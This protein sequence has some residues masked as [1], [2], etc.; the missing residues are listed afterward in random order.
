[1]AAK[2]HRLDSLKALLQQSE[3]PLDEV[4]K[5][6][7]EMVETLKK[8]EGADLEKKE[9]CESQREEDTASARKLSL[10]I[11][12]L[13]DVMTRNEAKIK[14][15]KAIIEEKEAEIKK[16][17][18]ELA[19]A[20]ANREKEK[21]AY[22]AAK[23]DDE[24]AAELIKKA[25]ETLKGF[26]EENGLTLVQRADQ[27]PTVEAGKAPP[28][29]PPTWEE[30]YGGAK[31]ESTGIQAILQMILEDVEADIK[32]A[33]AAEKE[34]IEE[35]EKFKKDTEEAIEA[36]NKAIEDMKGEIAT[37]EENIENA[38]TERTDKMGELKSVMEEIKTAEPG[39]EFMT[40][41]FLVR[42]KNRQLEIDG[43]LKAKAIL[44][45]GTY[46][47]G[48]DPNREIKSGDAM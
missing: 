11:D 2:D 10:N 7:D 26:Y 4:I 24:A 43:L 34:A 41:N 3:G 25:M 39:C 14:E 12:D 37:C 20:T 8:E 15:L 45:G 5:M 32:K 46:D 16:M 6:I 42:S 44:E 31:G 23:A 13:T 35:Y 22:E 9:T 28:P 19:E 47:E 40:I 29:P 17:E 1:V 27:P 30:P 21:L 38:K 18:E 33:E 36:A 48:P